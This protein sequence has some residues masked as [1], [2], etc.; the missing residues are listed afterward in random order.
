[1]TGIGF[2]GAGTIFLRKDFVRGLTTAATIWATAAIGMAAA[3]GQY[4][5]AVLTTLLILIVL[6]VLKPIELRLFRRPHESDV[7]F[8]MPRAADNVERVQAA[9]QTIGVNIEAVRLNEVSESQERYEM[10]LE[11]PVDCSTSKLLA[12]L[13]TVDGIRSI[14]IAQELPE[15]PRAGT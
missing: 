7:A 15:R 14:S 2:L 3:T 9:L 1:V 12:Q 6:M 11:V 5:A 13:R 4:F 8:E 10:D